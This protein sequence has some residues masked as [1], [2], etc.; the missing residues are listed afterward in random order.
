MDH[1]DIIAAAR[2]R[3]AANTL[4]SLSGV[5]CPTQEWVDYYNARHLAPRDR[6]G[7]AVVAPSLIKLKAR[8]VASTTV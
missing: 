6:E 7:F 5:A 3:R 8:A 2:A 4:F 1:L